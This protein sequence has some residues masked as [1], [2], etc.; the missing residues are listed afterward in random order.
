MFFF[1]RKRTQKEWAFVT[2]VPACGLPSFLSLART[3]QAARALT[4]ALKSRTV[5]KIYWA[6]TVGTPDP[7]EGRIVAPLAK[8]EGPDGERMM[9][10]EERGDSARTKIG[11]ASWRARGCPSM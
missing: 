9:V 1:C 3:A 11:R 2:G 10:N 5:R 8:G 4:A 7:Q 6:V